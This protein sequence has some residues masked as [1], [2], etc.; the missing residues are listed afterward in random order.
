MHTCPKK[1]VYRSEER[2]IIPDHRVDHALGD[3]H[4]VLRL[5]PQRAHHREAHAGAKVDEDALVALAIL[6]VIAHLPHGIADGHLDIAVSEEH[7]APVDRV[8]LGRHRRA[9][10]VAHAHGVHFD[11]LGL[12]GVQR[13]P[14]VDLRRRV[15][16]VHRARRPNKALGTEE[17]LGIEHAVGPPELRVTLF[18]NGAESVIVR[19]V[20]PPVSAESFTIRHGSGVGRPRR[21]VRGAQRRR[22]FNGSGCSTTAGEC[23]ANGVARRA[24]R[25]RRAKVEARERSRNRL[26]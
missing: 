4:V 11:V 7:D 26:Y 5:K 19:H 9:L 16:V 23:H 14:A 17:L 20:G 3:D 21:G 1:E 10:D 13:F 18:G 24:A 22:V 15:D 12:S 8:A 2:R 6:V 25:D